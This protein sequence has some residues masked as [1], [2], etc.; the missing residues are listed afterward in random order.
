MYLGTWYYISYIW[1]ILEKIQRT[2]SGS[3][4]VILNI[5]INIFMDFGNKELLTV[6]G[7]ENWNNV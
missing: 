3:I 4:G 7:K 2:L 5:H 1:N 6:R